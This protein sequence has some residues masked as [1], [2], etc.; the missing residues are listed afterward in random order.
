M[1]YSK[2][3]LRNK[4]IYNFITDI[5]TCINKHILSIGCLSNNKKIK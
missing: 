5:H 2:S 3:Y 4:I 1:R